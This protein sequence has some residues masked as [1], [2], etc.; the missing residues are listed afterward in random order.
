MTASPSKYRMCLL[1]FRNTLMLDAAQNADKNWVGQKCAIQK[2]ARSPHKAARELQ[3]VE[4][5]H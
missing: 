1:V 2:R 5:F 3:H 4:N